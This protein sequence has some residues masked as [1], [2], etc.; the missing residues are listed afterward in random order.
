MMTPF[1]RLATTLTLTLGIALSPISSAPAKAGDRNAEAIIAT[2]LGLA[3]VGAI[4]DHNRR[5][6]REERDVR[7]DDRDPDGVNRSKILPGKCLRYFPT[8]R[9]GRNYMGGNCLRKHYRNSHLL[10]T[11]CSMDIDTFNRRGDLVRRTVYRQG[12]LSRSGFYI[13]NR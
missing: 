9:G 2:I 6:R 7:P 12:C 11:H 4:I 1:A 13:P 3:V 10:P 5:D 8:V